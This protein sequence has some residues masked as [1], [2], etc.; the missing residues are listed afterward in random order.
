ML[1]VANIYTHVGDGIGIG[2][3][4]GKANIMTKA[5][6]GTTLSAMFGKSQY[7]DPYR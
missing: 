2:L 6:N 4:S 5:G 7:Y 3:F 1:G